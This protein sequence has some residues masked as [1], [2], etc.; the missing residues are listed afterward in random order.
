MPQVIEKRSRY[1][2]FKK[3]KKCM[4][5]RVGAGKGGRAAPKL[6]GHKYPNSEIF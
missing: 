2:I 3:K 6:E 1:I 5:Q 4:A